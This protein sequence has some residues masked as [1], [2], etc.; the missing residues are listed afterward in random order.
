MT[1]PKLQSESWLSRLPPWAGALAALVLLFVVTAI[2][3][4]QFLSAGNLMNIANRNVAVG[5][6]AVGMTLVIII[7]GIDLGVGALMVFCIGV[8]WLAHNAAIDAVGPVGA[9][10]IALVT[11]TLVGL[12]AGLLNGA[13]VTWGRI[14]AFIVTLAGLT[15]Y[16]SA[17]SLLADGGAFRFADN[18]LMKEYL[19]RGIPIPGTDIAASPK[20]VLPLE[21]PYGLLLLLAVVA[22]GH[23]LLRHT[24]FGRYLIATGSNKRAARYSAIPVTRIT[25]LTYA[26]IGALTGLAAMV[27]AC[28]FMSANSGDTGNLYE[29]DA[30][31]AVVIGG[32]RMRGGSGSVI[33]TLIGVLLMALIGNA[34]VMLGIPSL[35]QGLVKGLIIIGAVLAQRFAGSD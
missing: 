33:G 11:M 7:G 1:E 13:L 32:T 23:V 35:A 6:I 12:L 18:W 8:G 3:R 19:G 2:F 15:A 28:K 9:T 20:V 4:P 5:I 25:I 26:L 17:A 27:H 21:L 24:R 30:I 22:A 34:M 16:R 14:A 10:C 29:L 31:A